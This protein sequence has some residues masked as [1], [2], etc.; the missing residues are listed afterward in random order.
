M[1]RNRITSCILAGATALSLFALPALAAEKDVFPETHLAAAVTDSAV[2]VKES[3]D[4]GRD[5]TVAGSQA[6]L[7]LDIENHKDYLYQW[8][9]L[10]EDGSWSLVG[11]G[12]ASVY[13]VKNLKS[14]KTYTFRCIVSTAKGQIIVPTRL[15]NVTME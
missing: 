6:T 1:K 14:G 13:P 3:A 12:T 15:I 8:E 2:Y 4:R 5:I 7:V 9:Y 11:G 10:A